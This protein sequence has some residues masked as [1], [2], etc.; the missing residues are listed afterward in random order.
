MR[1]HRFGANA[2]KAPALPIL[3]DIARRTLSLPGDALEAVGLAEPTVRLG[4]TGLARAGKTVFI[5]SLVANLLERGRMPQLQAAAQGR[6]E[7]A[8]LRPQPDDTVPRFPFEEALAALT[9]PHPSWPEPTESVSAIRI[10]LRVRP[11]GML[12]GVRG[13]RVLNLDLVDYPGEWLLDL[14]LLEKGFGEWSNGALARLSARPGGEG[15]AAALAGT[16]AAGPHDEGAAKR[17]AGAYVEALRAARAAGFSDCTPGR[18]LMPGEMAGSPALTFAPLPAGEAPRGSLRREFARRFEAYK[19]RVVRPFFRDHFARIDRQV[20]LVDALE[21]IHHGPEAVGDLRGAMA[22]LLGAFRPG[23]NAFLSRLL[24]GRRIDRVLFAATKA[25]HLHHTQH[26]R[27]TAAMEA[28]V[29]DARRRAEFAGAR[30]GAMAIAALRATDEGEV[31]GHPVVRGLDARTGG[32][33]AFHPGD[34]PEDPAALLS[35]A[36]GGW[37]AEDYENMRFRPAPLTLRPGEGPPHIRLD[38]AAEFLF[39]DRL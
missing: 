37:L 24:R 21:A 17:L 2:R 23:G 5:T 33:V 12:A 19:A 28:L 1:A 20:V 18:F 3:D 16:D 29:A 15:F 26:G 6:I 8:Y 32:A 25:D 9:G 38:R 30:T 35:G 39:G 10:G 13:A 27:L 34:L 31:D 7:A 22:D 4:V 14:G 36:G 11:A